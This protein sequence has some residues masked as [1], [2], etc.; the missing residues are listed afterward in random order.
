VSTEPSHTHGGESP[1]PGERHARGRRRQSTIAAVAAAA[2]LAGG[3][4][5]WA[6]AGGGGPA[7][8]GSEAKP[9]PLALDAADSKQPQGGS[10]EGRAGIAPGEPA[11]AHPYRAA[12]KLPSGPESAA[13]YRA[14]GG[15]PRETV[16]ALAKALGVP[17]TPKRQHD[18]WS[19]GGGDR[20]GSGPRLT[21]NDD[22]SAGTWTYEASGPGTGRQGPSAY[23]GSH[24]PDHTTG[25]PAV[26]RARAE[27]AVRPA[28]KALGLQ[29]AALDAAT[30]DSSTRTVTAAPR[31]GGM[32]TMDWESTLAVGP[33][34]KVTRGHGTLG[35]LGKGPAYPV[36]SARETLKELNKLRARGGSAPGGARTARAEKGGGGGK[37]PGTPG[38]EGS[39]KVEGADFGLVTHYDHGRPVLVPSWIYRVGLAAGHTARVAHPAVQPRYLTPPRSGGSGSPGGSAGPGPGRAGSTPSGKGG[40]A[41]PLQDVKSYEASG[42]ILTLSFWG[43][44]CGGYRASAA[45]SAHSVRIAVERKDPDPK[46]VCVKMA[47]RQ[48]VRVE[49]DRPLGDRRV[50]DGADGHALTDG[51]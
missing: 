18:G 5:Y 14:A 1:S 30:T 10:R 31:V 27:Q 51:K 32:P 11:G 34:G 26:S 49:L 24:S 22:K 3:G 41:A 50:V 45:E 12:G 16:A 6:S 48:T 13:V 20:G 46:K 2:L 36:M 7:E 4:A 29:N 47:K 8:R 37:T 25:Q 23:P 21:V 9:P 17:G 40:A 35:R 43:G 33:D 28:L 38:P 42:R 15:P 19:V 39:V 44:V